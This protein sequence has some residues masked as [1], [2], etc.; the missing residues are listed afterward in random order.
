[1][2]TKSRIKK[3]ARELF[4]QNGVQNIT[5]RH[6]AEHLGISY[7]NVTYHY[8]NKSLLLEAIYE[9]MNIELLQLQ[10]SVPTPLNLLEYFLLLP[11]YNFDIS[12]KYIFFFKD[13]V[14]LK[15]NFKDFYQKVELANQGR[16]VKWIELLQTLQHQDF[17]NKSL[18]TNDLK[19]IIDLSIGI[20]MFYFQNTE[21]NDFDKSIF[22]DQVNRLLLP[23]L[24]E[25]GLQ[26]YQ[27]VCKLE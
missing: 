17:L 23:Y 26:V 11:D 14:E 12:T 15:R 1:M 13:F 22:R 21:I 4:N 3:V 24:T 2:N 27:S 5:L 16:K 9:E 10:K 25:K 19:Y 8:P 6:I 18:E 7:G 20:R